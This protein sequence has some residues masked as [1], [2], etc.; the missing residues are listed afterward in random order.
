[1]IS[2]A[3]HPVDIRPLARRWR[4]G[5]F[6]AYLPWA[7]AAW[8]LR[9]SG[10]RQANSDRSPWSPPAR[11]FRFSAFDGGCGLDGGSCRVPSSSGGEG[12]I[13]PA[14]ELPAWG[15][16]GRR[17]DH[18]SLSSQPAVH[19]PAAARRECRLS[20]GTAARTIRATAGEV[21]PVSQFGLGGACILRP[22]LRSVTRGDT[23]SGASPWGA[24]PA[25]TATPSRPI[26][27][28]FA[29]LT[30]G[31][32]ADFPVVSGCCWRVS[33]AVGCAYRSL[34]ATWQPNAEPRFFPTG[35]G[36]V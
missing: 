19:S 31:L 3:A 34:R 13:G 32:G 33:S 27:S 15:R 4:M 24:P 17:R 16:S 2:A 11:S 20:P 9:R 28:R 18:F 35:K 1:M 30:S 21:S 6:L 7:G 8:P 36:A 12:R 26:H 25:R 10:G 22:A 5:S 14:S 23:S 29:R